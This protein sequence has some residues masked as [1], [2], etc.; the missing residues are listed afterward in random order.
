MLKE[1]EGFYVSE[2]A[3]ALT[4]QLNLLRP[5]EEMRSNVISLEDPRVPFQRCSVTVSP[6][7][8]VPCRLSQSKAFPLEWEPDYI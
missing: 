6:V 1:T 3:A 2:A 4:L 5:G 8:L 7:L